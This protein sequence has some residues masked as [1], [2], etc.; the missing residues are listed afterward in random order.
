ML[1]IINVKT[2]ILEILELETNWK[3]G[4]KTLETG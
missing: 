3:L 4:T 2:V 1:F